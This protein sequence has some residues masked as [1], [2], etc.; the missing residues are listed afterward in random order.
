MKKKNDDPQTQQIINPHIKNFSTNKIKAHA[1]GTLLE[2]RTTRVIHGYNVHGL[3]N[4][5][6][7]NQLLH[8]ILFLFIGLLLL[9]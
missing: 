3:M 1:Y 2:Q 7:K 8:D 4:Q 9:W 6:S 5:S